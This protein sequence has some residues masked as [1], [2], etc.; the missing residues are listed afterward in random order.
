MA[1]K[2]EFSEHELAKIM[3]NYNLGKY[4]DSEPF[5]N[6]NVQTNIRIQTT[7]GQFVFRYYENRTE[8]SVLF[9]T[10]L[11][12]FLKNHNYPCPKPI[13]NKNGKFVNSYNSKPYAVFDY[14]EGHHVQEPNEIQKK[15]LIQMAA[16]LH[17]ITKDY[18]P[19]YKE[20]RWN[21]NVEFCKEQAQ[22]ASER[23]N[24]LHSK[25][26]FSWLKNGL[27]ELNLPQ[28][29][30]KGICHADFHFSNVLFNNGEFSALLDF[31]DAN[32]TYLLFDLVGLLE[33]WAWRYDQNEFINFNE[34]RKIV[35]EY[36]K[37][38]PLE[39]VE[40]KHLFDVYKLSIF[41]DC[42]W[43]FER[44]D[45]EDFYEKRKIDYLDHIGRQR[46]F[47]ELF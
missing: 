6:G 23:I 31:D 9:E 1:A 18:Q 26:K 29:L 39:T 32:Y 30:P 2:T 24:N 17:T 20:S 16:E 25:K 45:S 15:Q 38:R 37:H 47:E 40:K 11:L 3:T 22:K 8:N 34:A 42:V 5:K 7:N 4:I 21:Y 13:E 10:E 43:F 35:L 44:G 36:V 33:S 27:N 19:I 41:I 14:M 28:S 46:F 12:R